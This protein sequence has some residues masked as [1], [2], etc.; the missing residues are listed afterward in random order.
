METYAIY[1]WPRGALSSTIGSDTL[2]GA[3]CWGLRVLGLEDVTAMLAHFDPPRFAFSGAFPAVRMGRNI[4][5]FYPR[6]LTTDPTLEDV[7]ALSGDR[8]DR[9]GFI[10]RKMVVADKAK[11][12]KRAAWVSEALLREMT[13]R[14]M[15]A[16]DILLRV[17]EVRYLQK[18]LP[19]LDQEKIVLRSGVLMLANEAEKVPAPLWETATVQHNTVDRVAGATVEGLL[20]YDEERFFAP[21]VGLW[22]L[23]RAR[24]E[25]ID[26]LIR[27]A[28]RYLADTGLGANRSV[29]KGHF[30]IEVVPAPPVPDAGEAGGGTLLLSR[31]VPRE[32]E[33]TADGHMAYRLASIWAKR[34]QKF[35]WSQPEQTSPPIYKRRIRAFEPGSVLPLPRREIYGR[36]TQVVPGEGNPWPVY[37][38]GLALGLGLK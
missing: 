11:Q 6:P 16:R 35:P 4:T 30:A 38:S 31:Y 9:V 18:G 2:F 5:H 3:V 34:E 25:D 10:K 28:L 21:G 8:S 32:G 7:N 1:L 19:P 12:L 22:C 36:L 20:F 37:Q 29:G 17:P 13:A 14:K 33:F 23:V 27:P 26:G 15:G 24:Q